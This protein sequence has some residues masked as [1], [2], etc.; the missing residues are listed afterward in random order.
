MLLIFTLAPLSIVGQGVGIGTDYPSATL[1]VVGTFQ[2]DNGAAI[3]DVLT[4]TDVN[5]NTAWTDPATLGLEDHDWHKVSGGADQGQADTIGNDVY[6]NGSVGIGTTAPANQLH[7][8]ENSSGTSYAH[9]TNF[10][11]GTNASDGFTVGLSDNETGI[12][13]MRENHSL[14]FATNGVQ[15]MSLTTDGTFVAE[16]GAVINEQGGDRDSRIESDDEPYMLFVDASTNRIGIGTSA[17]Q[18][19]LHLQEDA[20]TSVYARF[21][22][23]DN[24]KGID[25]GARGGGSLGIIQRDNFSIDFYTNEVER[26][27]LSND[28]FLG[29]GESTPRNS[30][31]LG[32]VGSIRFPNNEESQPSLAGISDGDHAVLFYDRWYCNMTEAGYPHFVCNQGGLA[33]YDD[34]GWCGLVSTNNMDRLNAVFWSQTTVSDMRL[35]ENTKKVSDV[36]P[37]LEQIQAYTYNMIEDPDKKHHYG[38]MAQEVQKVY[39]D[40]VRV[41]NEEGHLAMNYTQLVPILVEAVKELK[42]ENDALK[43]QL[44]SEIE[45]IKTIL[46]NN[47]ITIESAGT[48]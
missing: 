15:G 2:L 18:Q 14:R 9:F 34:E 4:A 46:S 6:T 38:V 8:H 23:S 35:K 24:T 36:F 33:L 17:P 37:K 41:F 40:M 13:W 11:T 19:I 1:D 47:N 22:N 28:G 12:I 25:I 44:S 31:D 7:I 42:A 20:S 16:N 45:T 27:K 43:T 30:L 10:T 3:G 26:M 21:A 39:P 29:I 5:G 32:G 48:K